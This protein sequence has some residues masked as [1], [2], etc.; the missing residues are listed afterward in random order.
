MPSVLYHLLPNLDYYRVQYD[1]KNWDS[2]GRAL[3]ENPTAI[4]YLN[5]MQIIDDIF[6][7]ADVG[8]IKYLIAFKISRYLKNEREY[9]PLKAM[10]ESHQLIHYK[11]VGSTA[12]ETFRVI[13]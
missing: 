11:L 10:K 4:H 2:I 13:I 7:F 3:M 6:S 1:D 5:R 9:A 8:M 12:Y